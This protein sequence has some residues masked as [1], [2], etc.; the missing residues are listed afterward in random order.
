MRWLATMDRQDSNSR[1]RDDESP[2]PVV[3]GEHES[4]CKHS[5]AS[6]SS[7]TQE[8]RET[9]PDLA[10]LIDAWP[11]L[12]EPVKA[13][14]RAMRRGRLVERLAI[15]LGSSPRWPSSRDREGPLGQR[16]A[17]DRRRRACWAGR[18]RVDVPCRCTVSL[19]IGMV[20]QRSR[21]IRLSSSAL[22][23]LVNGHPAVS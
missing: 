21:L 12:P 8:P 16:T 2:P 22:E 13:G 9:D 15:S 1:P 5:N 4:D 20:G 23:V 17:H 3:S 7:Q 6:S 14:I 19:K 11:T 18:C 10:K